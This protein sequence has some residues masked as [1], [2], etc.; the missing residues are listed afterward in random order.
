MSFRF[1]RRIRLAPGLTLNLS[2][3]MASL[4][5]SPQGAEYTISPRG[6]RAKAGLMGT[7]LFH[8]VNPIWFKVMQEKFG[9]EK[10]LGDVI[11]MI[12]QIRARA[13]CTT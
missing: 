3:S 2:K 11:D 7:G 1:W 5:V 12:D 8:T 10:T 6:N 4:S 13:G 9:C